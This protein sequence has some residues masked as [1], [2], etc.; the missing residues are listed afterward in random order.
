[1]AALPALLVPAIVF[2]I[3]GTPVPLAAF[4]SLPQVIVDIIEKAPPGKTITD[5]MPTIEAVSDAFYP[6]SGIA[7]A[8]LFYMVTH[9][10][11]PTPE[12]QQR[13]WDQAQG[14]H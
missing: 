6:G 1:M 7:E 5:L 8:V 9:A 12:D 14:I 13:M 3:A 4:K 10:K 11:P 2:H